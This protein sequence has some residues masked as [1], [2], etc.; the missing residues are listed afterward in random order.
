MPPRAST[1]AR[2]YPHR[3]GQRAVIVWPARRWTAGRKAYQEELL[4]FGRIAVIMAARKSTVVSVNSVTFRCGRQLRNKVSQAKM[5]SEYGAS[6]HQVS[7]FAGE[8]KRQQW[9]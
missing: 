5:T 4:D 3:E 7:G 6:G 8:E 2:L 1:L 9:L